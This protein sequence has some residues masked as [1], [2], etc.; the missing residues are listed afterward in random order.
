M[1]A[2]HQLFDP[3]L[4]IFGVKCPFFHGWHPLFI[5]WL[6]SSLDF[7]HPL[8]K[9]MDVEGQIIS[10]EKST[11]S[12]FLNKRFLFAL[13]VF[14]RTFF[15]FFLSTSFL[16]FISLSKRGMKSKQNA[17]KVR[18]SVRKPKRDY[19]TTPTA[20]TASTAA[21]T[22]ACAARPLPARLPASI[23]HSC[24]KEYKEIKI[25]KRWVFW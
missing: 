13:T 19:I 23:H 14:E 3:N 4:T 22:T 7:S 15:S 18:F 21:A 8:G 9:K 1:S 17:K 5:L 11:C 2:H 6:A 16:K 25:R 24:G 20:A 12:V 10:W